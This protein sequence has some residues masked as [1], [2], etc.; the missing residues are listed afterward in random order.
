MRLVDALMK[1]AF[2]AK[3]VGAAEPKSAALANGDRL[4]R[5]MAIRARTTTPVP[6][7]AMPQSPAMASVLPPAGL[8]ASRNPAS[9]PDTAMAPIHSSR[10]GW[11][12]D[13]IDRM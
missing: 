12:R 1:A 9:P 6:A 7:P 13:Q 10:P 8:A 2:R 5:A 3:V 11:D 4:V